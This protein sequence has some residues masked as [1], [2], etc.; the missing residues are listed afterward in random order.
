[1]CDAAFRKMSLVQYHNLCFLK[2]EFGS[3]TIALWCI[4]LTATQGP[5]TQGV[6]LTLMPSP[7]PAACPKSVILPCKVIPSSAER[8]LTFLASPVSSAGWCAL[9]CSVIHTSGQC[10]QVPV[11]P[12]LTCGCKCYSL[13]SLLFLSCVREGALGYQPES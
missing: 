2:E 1:M 10:V 8:C 5:G 3:L 6:Y 9:L 4:V 12:P 11:Q 7:V 13:F